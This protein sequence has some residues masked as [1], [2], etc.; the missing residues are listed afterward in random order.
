MLLMTRKKT[1]LTEYHRRARIRV[2]TS[3]DGF[4]RGD[5]A[6]VHVDPVVAGWIEIGVVEIV[7]ELGGPDGEAEAGQGGAEPD[8]LGDEQA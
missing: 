2:R 4:R 6:E 3:F 5:E 8:V 1:P 7:E